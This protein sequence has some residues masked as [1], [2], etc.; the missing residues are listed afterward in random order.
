MITSFHLAFFLIH[1][2]IANSVPTFKISKQV[3]NI[4]YLHQS[5]E[6]NPY[7]VHYQNDK[8]YHFDNIYH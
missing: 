2:N 4:S 6:K 5:V 7:N 3:S 8:Y 1:T